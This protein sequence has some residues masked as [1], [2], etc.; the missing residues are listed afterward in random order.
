MNRVIIFNVSKKSFIHLILPNEILLTLE[1]TLII[2]YAFSFLVV[3]VPLR[4]RFVLEV[5]ICPF[6]SG[7]IIVV[8]VWF[9]ALSPALHQRTLTHVLL[10]PHDTR[11]TEEQRPLI[12]QHIKHKIL[13]PKNSH[14]TLS[15]NGVYDKVYE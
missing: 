9:T 13:K 7:V 15:C 12:F 14:R 2:F 11:I 1:I 8:F 3:T 10:Y 6:F 4:Q 5:Y